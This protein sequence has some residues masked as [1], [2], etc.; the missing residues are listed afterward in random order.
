MA[1]L[2]AAQAQARLA[3]EQQTTRRRALEYQRAMEAMQEPAAEPGLEAG[4]QA[5]LP[6]AAA[7]AAAAPRRVT[8]MN[9]REL[10]ELPEEERK[11]ELDRRR[12]VR[13][14]KAARDQ[15]I[16]DGE[17]MRSQ[18]AQLETEM[19]AKRVKINGLIAKKRKLAGELAEEKDK[20]RRLTRFLEARGLLTQ[21]L[22]E[23]LLE[24]EVPAIEEVEA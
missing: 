6:A 3:L 5:A 7:A 1:E 8:R 22:A 24:Q 14:R 2:E 9:L 13:E 17:E 23:E 16:A 21:A 15:L 10:G 18:V 12:E 4:T 20:V 19:E 11:A